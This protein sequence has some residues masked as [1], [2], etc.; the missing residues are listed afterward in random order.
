V[1]G[2]GPLHP[3]GSTFHTPPTT[4]SARAYVDDADTNSIKLDVL[5]PPQRWQ[6]RVVG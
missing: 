3:P 5:K 6:A 4:L 2:G 1:G